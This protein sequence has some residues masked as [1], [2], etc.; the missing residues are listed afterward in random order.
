MQD[1]SVKCWPFNRYIG[2][3]KTKPIRLVFTLLSPSRCSAVIYQHTPQKAAHTPLRPPPSSPA[4]RLPLNNT[5]PARAPLS[6]ADTP[7][8]QPRGSQG[9]RSAGTVPRPAGAGSRRPLTS[10][11]CL[12]RTWV[13]HSSSLFTGA[14]HSVQLRCPRLLYV[15][16]AVK[17]SRGLRRGL[18]VP[19]LTAPPP[20]PHPRPTGPAPEGRAGKPPLPR[21]FGEGRIDPLLSRV[22]ALLLPHE[23]PQLLLPHLLPTRTQPRRRH[24][25]PATTAGGA[26]PAARARLRRGRAGRRRR[27]RGL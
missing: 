24:L 22:L 20:P 14:L 21:I 19:H 10:R 18:P 15:A 5:S 26:V 17:G 23:A 27:G 11:C 1:D 8:P 3:K 7:Y 12:P 4:A 9:P 16:D 13:C 25:L 6:P 2:F